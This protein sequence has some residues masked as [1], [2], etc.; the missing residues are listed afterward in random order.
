MVQRF[1]LTVHVHNTVHF[2]MSTRIMFQF[3]L[4]YL[5]SSLLGIMCRCMSP[6]LGKHCSSAWGQR[7]LMSLCY[8]YIV[9]V[10]VHVHV[11]ILITCTCTCHWVLP[12]EPHSNCPTSSALRRH[13][14]SVVWGGGMG[15]RGGGRGGGWEGER[16]E[17][18]RGGNVGEGEVEALHNIFT[19]W[20]SIVHVHV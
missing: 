9:H 6:W 11:C 4:Q 2:K 15:R 12:R 8:R 14:Y 18:E 10:H 20:N 16:G 3:L 1:Q 13:R 19:L 17:R 7:L 5:H